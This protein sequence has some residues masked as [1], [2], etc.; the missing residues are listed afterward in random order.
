MKTARTTMHWIRQLPARTWVLLALPAILT[1]SFFAISQSAPASNPLI[2][3]SSEPLYAKGTRDKPTLT[4]ALS[5][6]FPTV[7]AQYTKASS[8]ELDDTYAP[9]S[10]Y[11]GYFDAE[12]CYTY[13][14]TPTEVVSTDA[15][16]SDYKRFVRSRAATNRE[17]GG[18]GFSGNFMNWATSSAID[19]L[20][21]G[22]TG[23]DRFIDTSTLTVLQRAVIQRDMFINSY[24]PSKKLLATYSSGALPSTLLG[25]HT[26]DLYV[27]NCLNK[28]YFGTGNTTKG[29]AA[30]GTFGNND[31]APGT[32][33]NL[34]VTG[35]TAGTTALATTQN[36]F[37]SRVQVCD[38]DGAGGTTDKRKFNDDNYCVKYPSGSYKPVGNL[39]RYSDSMRVAVFGYL[40][41]SGT[42]RYGGVLRSPMKYVGQRYYD[43]SGVLYAADNPNTEWDKTT[44]VFVAN[45]DNQAEGISGA[46]NYINKF[47]RTAATP[48]AYKGND[49]VGELYYEALRYLQGLPPTSGTTEATDPTYNMTTAQKDGFPVYSS[50][51]DPHAGGVSTN[52]YTCLK[53]NLFTIGDIGTHAD[54][55]IPGNTRTGGDDVARPAL[56]VAFNEPNFVEWTKVVGKFEAGQSYAYK[57]GLASTSATVNTANPNSS[58]YTDLDNLETLTT[59]GSTSGTRSF[60]IAGMAYWAKNHDIRSTDWTDQPDKQRP[61]MRVTTYMLDVNQNA[62]SASTATRRKSQFFLAAKYG[63]FNDLTGKGNPYYNS[64]TFSTSTADNSVWDKSNINYFNPTQPGEARTHFLASDARGVLTTLSNIFAAIARDGYS[65]AGGAISTQRLTSVGGFIYQAQFGASDWTGDLVSQYVRVDSNNNVTVST[66]TVSD[67]HQWSAADKLQAKIIA[68]PDT[69]TRNIVVGKTTPTSSGTATN[70]TWSEIDTDLQDALNI[71]SGGTTADGRGEDRLN[72]IRGVRTL[73]GTT[74]SGTAFRK[75]GGLLGDIV[76]SAVTYSGAPGTNLS[77]STDYETFATTYA[78]RTKALFVGAND[79]MLHAFNANSGEEIFGYI[80]SWLKSRLSAL[81]NTNYNSNHRSYVDGSPA[82]AE[83]QVGTDWKTVLVSGTGAGGQGVFALDVSDPDAFGPSKVL[84][85][86]TDRDDADLGNV[87]GRPQILKFRTSAS[88][89]SPATY[90]WFAV[91]PSGVNNNANDGYY[92]TTGKPALF[93]L[94]LSKSPS[95][96]WQ[97]NVNYYKI[98]LTFSDSALPSGVANFAATEGLSGEVSHIY[99]GDLQGNLWKLDFSQKGTSDWNLDSLSS[100]RSSTAPNPAIPFF[101]A[102]DSS[103]AVQPITGSPGL[104][105]GPYGSVLVI[106]GTG[107]YLETADNVV[108]SSTQT[109]SMYVLMDNGTN[110][111]S[112]R[113]NLASGTV[114]TSTGGIT[115]PSFTWGVYQGTS[116]TYRPG[117]FIDFP[118]SGERQVSSFGMLGTTV[119][120]GSVIPPNA[121]TDPCGSGSGYQYVA[122]I[123]NGIGTRSV[124]QVGLLGEPFVLEMGSASV[125]ALNSLRQATKT[126]TGQIILQG[127]DGLKVV[128]GDGSGG[129]FN[130]TTTVGR[131]SWRQISNY[132]ELKNAP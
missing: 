24:F 72:F 60:Y 116:Y 81:T 16:Y 114:S 99:V 22:L 58:I 31:G 2:S 69:S 109:Q 105:R 12:S 53:N 64:P 38:S 120:F 45:P 48:G 29:T 86:F 56:G 124:S 78:N 6:E 132:F 67:P 39:Q 15:N 9:T 13:N 100:F 75:R 14:D 119:I 70:F 121:V 89:A 115:T 77:G 79:G 123:S 19:M 128:V 54:K 61:G 74:V 96:S 92:S 36:Y 63:G 66:G 107:K 104:S 118:N 83:A 26:G 4:L 91:V 93:L 34:G 88:T 55:Y 76:N 111:I 1:I 110:R 40:Y 71:P 18:T 5:V 127:S 52:D 82:V 41:Q 131:L 103:G 28:I 90:K 3:L 7:G 98:S 50:W 17:C 97:E 30:C 42:K 95:T 57:P 25:T 49:P 33:G 85:E 102:T 84:W 62:S 20:R 125:S 68:T 11:I 106:V 51:T 113:S 8:P 65:I 122:N 129:S 130:S 126:T 87:I 35:G 101:I 32:S 73:E 43:S 27:A 37:F 47:G 44:G 108:T 117:W 80:P 21:M 94:D 112:A 10:E 23:G 59:A 46:I